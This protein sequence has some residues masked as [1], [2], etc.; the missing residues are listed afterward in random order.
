MSKF[1][2]RFCQLEPSGTQSS[3]RRESN[4]LA[5]YTTGHPHPH[6][7]EEAMCVIPGFWPFFS[8]KP[9]SFMKS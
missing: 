1:S 2:M 4:A 6:Y 9:I 8:M 5:G 3:H 7:V